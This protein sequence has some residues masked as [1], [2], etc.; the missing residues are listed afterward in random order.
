M[1]FSGFQSALRPRLKKDL[2]RTPLEEVYA[3]NE[4]ANH[5]NPD[6]RTIFL[7]L[8]S[9]WLI[10]ISSKA[11]REDIS[12]PSG[13]GQISGVL[14]LVGANRK[15]EIKHRLKQKGIRDIE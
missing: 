2:S 10:F 3:G 5:Q 1:A 7:A 6:R 9:G 14:L 15:D 11:P 8:S 12:P 4:A 13:V